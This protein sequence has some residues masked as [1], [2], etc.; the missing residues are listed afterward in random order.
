M[1]FWSADFRIQA[2]FGCDNTVQRTR[3]INAW[4]AERKFRL[5]SIAGCSKAHA[6]LQMTESCQSQIG[7]E[8]IVGEVT[9]HQVYDQ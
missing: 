3:P 4:R 8:Q 7:S 6:L 9:A 1:G 5:L 2:I